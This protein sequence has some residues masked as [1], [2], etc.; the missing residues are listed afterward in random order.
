MTRIKCSEVKNE[1]Y[2]SEA[3]F[4]SF[5]KVISLFSSYDNSVQKCNDTFKMKKT[6]KKNTRNYDILILIC[7]L[8]RV[9]NRMTNFY[10]V[11]NVINPDLPYY[12]LEINCISVLINIPI[13]KSLYLTVF[14]DNGLTV[15]RWKT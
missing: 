1:N 13:K 3:G 10:T 8:L 7:V 5:C 4:F 2:P 14:R 11:H 15:Y 6:N 9:S 12:V